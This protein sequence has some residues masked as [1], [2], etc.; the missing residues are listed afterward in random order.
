MEC[1]GVVVVKTSGL[2]YIIFIMVFSL[3]KEYIPRLAIFA[4]GIAPMSIWPLSGARLAHPLEVSAWS[5]AYALFFCLAPGRGA[6]FFAWL[7]IVLLPMTLAWIGTVSVMGSGPSD[8]LR[9]AAFSA[10]SG[11]IVQS[12]TMAIGKASFLASSAISFIACVWAVCASKEVATSGNTIGIAFITALLLLFA[13]QSNISYLRWAAAESESKIS[14]PWM[15]DV[16]TGAQMVGAAI[17]L[18]TLG[19]PRVEESSRKAVDAPRLFQANPGLAIFI[20]GESLR[21]DALMVDGRGPWS[22]ALKERLAAG[23]GV[24]AADACAGSNA[25]FSAVPGLLTMVDPSDAVKADTAPT[26]LA[27]AHAAGAK[28]AWITNQEDWVVIETGHD[29]MIKTAAGFDSSSLDETVVAALADFVK[30]N[31]DGA[32]AAILHLHGQHFNYVDRYPAGF[33]G[34]IPAALSRDAEEE[35]HYQRAAEYGVKVLLDV[36]AVLDKQ[37]EPAFLVFTSDH[38]ENLV[39]DGT[40]KKYHAGPVSGKFDTTVPVLFLWNKAFA[41]SSRAAKIDALVKSRELIAHRDVAKAWLL[42]DGMPGDF[43][44]LPS[45]MTLSSN[46]VVPCE[47]LPK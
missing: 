27:L 24:R 8:I 33:L 23:L 13:A 14:V 44:T 6:R 37:R 1:H 45:S 20:L 18:A 36:A 12:A 15:A 28:T 10:S 40:G 43:S 29:A 31:S 21:A 34:P 7:Q 47:T 4:A 26:I 2:A 39:S 35:L 38:G 11:E 42:L 9:G 32:K 46:V 41:Q 30:I 5:V 22:K 16:E 17:N 19:R 25:T 3:S